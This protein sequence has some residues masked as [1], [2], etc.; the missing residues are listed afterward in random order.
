MTS[1]LYLTLEKILDNACRGNVLQMRI[2]G[3]E[4]SKEL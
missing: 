2:L 1:T 3:P 4:K